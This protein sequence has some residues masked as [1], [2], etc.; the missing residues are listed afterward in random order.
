ML[1][2]RS[3]YAIIFVNKL[4]KSTCGVS[5][6]GDCALCSFL[7]TSHC[8]FCALFMFSGFRGATLFNLFQN[9]FFF[10]SSHTGVKVPFL[11]KVRFCI[12]CFYF[13]IFSLHFSWIL[14]AE[15]NACYKPFFELDFLHLCCYVLFLCTKHTFLWLHQGHVSMVNSIQYFFVFILF[16]LFLV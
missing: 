16:E 3:R 8:N 7:L 6:S 9:V 1:N 5:T 4:A 10:S 14:D 11:F 2:I 13:F 15:K 12:F